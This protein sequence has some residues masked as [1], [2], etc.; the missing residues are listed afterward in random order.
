MSLI[1]KPHELEI[2]TI[3]KGLIYG[4]PGIGKTTLALSAP[5]PVLLDFDA[6]VHRI[7]A[8][9]Q[10]PTMQVKAWSE[11]LTAIEAGDLNQFATLVIDTA[12]KM[13]EFMDDYIIANNP[14]LGSKL[15][16]LALQGYGVRKIEF[17]KFVQR[18]S[19]MGKH[20]IF[21]AHEIES[22]QEEGTYK[23]PEVGGSSGTDLY[24]ELDLIGYMEANGK[25]RIISFA[26]TDK[27]YAKNSCEL[28]EIIE[29]E[30]IK[31]GAKN[32]FLTENIIKVYKQRLADRKDTVQQYSEL[33]ELLEA[34][35]EECID[36][37]TLNEVL[38][39]I[40]NFTDHIWTSKLVA[41]KSLMEKSRL[42]P[43]IGFDRETKRFDYVVIAPADE[44]KV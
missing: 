35:I 30:E 32:N 44:T 16:K 22:K 5:D 28:N 7:R 37:D 4:Q 1:K 19:A 34:K 39:F 13:L 27:F 29:F 21:I 2:P 43:G 20:L 3:L 11:V 31:F 25:K 8:E 40:N 15:G 12:G 38:D 23:R 41:G 33:M 24:K 36:L 10:V 26:P 17:K 42:I 6:G 18:I 14:K 9:H